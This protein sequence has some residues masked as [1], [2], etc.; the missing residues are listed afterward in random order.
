MAT[1]GNSAL[2]VTLPSD[3][4]IAM[5]RA[6]NAPRSL[7]FEAFT[8]AEHLRH[9]W[10]LKG[11]TI[12]VLELDFRPG[13]AWRIVSREADGSEN[14][15]RGEFRE[16]APPERFTWT[17]EWEGLPGHITV[18]TVTFEERDGKTIVR[19][20]SSFDNVEDRDGML[21][22][23]MEYGAAESYERLDAYLESLA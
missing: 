2:T 15:F 7:V 16:V 5:E 13:G 11:S 18:E 22:S 21:Q 17:F 14:A 12:P 3:L 9:W 20:L 4:E 19:T 10:G 1:K 23:G 8:K 6:F